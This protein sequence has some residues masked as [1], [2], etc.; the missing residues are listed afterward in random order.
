[1]TTNLDAGLSSL[2]VVDTRDPRYQAMKGRVHEELLNRLNLE[3]LTRTRREDA[4]PEIRG[5][6][7]GLLD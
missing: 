5:L 7:T 3:R 2:T 1:M 4:E 6:I